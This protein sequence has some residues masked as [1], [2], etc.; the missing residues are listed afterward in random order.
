MKRILIALWS[1]LACPFL[2][3]PSLSQTVTPTPDCCLGMGTLNAQGGF[4]ESM[5]IRF[6]LAHDRLYVADRFNHSIHVLT[7][8]GVPLTLLSTWGS[9]ETFQQPHDVGVDG[10]GN[11]YVADYNNR[12]VVK[13]DQALGYI[14]SFGGVG[15]GF[16]RALWVESQAFDE[17][18]YV[19]T[20]SN[21]IQV[22]QGSGATYSLTVS[23]TQ[24]LDTPTG[25]VKQGNW[26]YV[27]DSMNGRVARF[28]TTLL[29]PASSTAWSSLVTPTGLEVDL[30]GNLYVSELGMGR[31]SAF[32]SGF[33]GF[34]HE[35]YVPNAWDAAVDST[36]KIH[37]SL[38][39]SNTV[40]L[41]QGCL[42]QPA[43]TPSPTASLPTESQGVL[44]PSPVRGDQA[45]FACDLQ[46][47]G[48]VEVRIF[49]ENG[50]WA[51]KVK[52]NG[53][54]GIKVTPIDVSRFSS[55]VYTYLAV[56]RYDSGEVV[57][58]APRRFA[59]IR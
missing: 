52:E 40:T 22:Y 25:V 38:L 30:A 32:S 26:L 43:L 59:V 35:C 55:G 45:F 8:A 15:M 47:S 37:G 7:A 2:A 28:D 5:G 53:F 31:I 11:L 4:N 42:S 49:N 58:S 50:E 56:I 20:Q 48:E 39:T 54:P 1:A 27:A 9:S 41:L 19:A 13:F 6:D 23:Y 24:G 33:G 46:E 29:N 51:A 34:L 57:R 10:Q 21:G 44:Y 14:T 17:K 36:G 3:G 16:P 18:V 12:R